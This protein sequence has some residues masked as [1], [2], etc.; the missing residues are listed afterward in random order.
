M[1]ILEQTIQVHASVPCVEQCFTD[2]DKMHEWLNPMLSC[3]P[4]GNEAWS[5]E[6]H[7][8][9][10][11]RLKIPLLN[12]VLRNQVIA[13]KPGLIVWQFN[14]FFCGQDRWEFI[15]NAN[16]TQLINRFEFD[17]PNPIIRWGFHTFAAHWTKQDM[18]AQLDRIK[19]LAEAVKL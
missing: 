12:L 8:Q 16:G 10:Q 1:E 17:I 3:Q 9:S 18:Q 11:F 19:T 13:R 4:V 14:G 5:T 2:L 15:P 7:S 6:L